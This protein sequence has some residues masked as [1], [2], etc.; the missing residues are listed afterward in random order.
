MLVKHFRNRA[1]MGYWYPI[2]S[3]DFHEHDMISMMVLRQETLPRDGSLR[4]GD[5]KELGR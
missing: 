2:V 3:I 4:I 5:A 1:I